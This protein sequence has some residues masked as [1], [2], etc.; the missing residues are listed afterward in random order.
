MSY[1]DSQGVKLYV[2]ETGTGYPL[3]FVHEIGRESCR[4]R[5]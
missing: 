4:E 1:A 3:V 2:E 5:V